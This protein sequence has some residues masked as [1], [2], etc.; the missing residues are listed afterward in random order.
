M[1]SQACTGLGSTAGDGQQ[2][3]LDMSA[4]SSCWLANVKL[5]VVA[6]VQCRQ[7]KRSA[8]SSA[9]ITCLRHK[10]RFKFSGR[11]YRSVTNKHKSWAG[12]GTR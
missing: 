2:F 7:E 6:G 9:L 4:I 8:S 11:E 5:E 12:D 1:A 3:E 10:R